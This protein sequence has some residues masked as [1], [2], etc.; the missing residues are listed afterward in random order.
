M[1]SGRRTALT[2]AALGL[3]IL[4]WGSTWSVIRVGLRGMPPLTG[5]SLRFAIAALL[6]FA[7]AW[8]RRIPLGKLPGE[9]RLWV[10]NAV[11]TFAISYGVVYWAEQWITSGLAAVLFATFPLFVALMA[12]FW[13]PGETLGWKGL[14][15]MVVGFA[16][17]GWIFSDDLIALGGSQ[18]FTASLVMLLSPISSA[19]GNV[20]VKRWG[21]DIHPISVTAVP[22]AFC[23]ALVGGLALLVERGETIAW[24]RENVLALLYLAIIGSAVTFTIYFWLLQRLPATRLS[25]MTYAIPIVAVVIGALWLDEPLGP[26]LAS[27]TVLVLCGVAL[28]AGDAMRRR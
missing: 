3:L 22:M 7:L 21:H 15:G 19:A 27:G 11:L 9:R 18:V 23:A 20:L 12:H 5:V 24:S 1:G 2:A 10:V 8:H 4:I 6:L 25:L 26:R 14:L 28:A 17:V 16:G 13:L